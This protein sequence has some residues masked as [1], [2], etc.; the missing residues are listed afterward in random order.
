MK[1]LLTFFLTA[2]LAFGVGWAT[3]VTM[4]MSDYYSTT[5][6]T[7]A[8]TISE[9]DVSITFAKGQGS[10]EPQYY[11]SGR[12]IRFYASNTMSISVSSGTISSV[13]VTFNTTNYAG[14]ASTWS[15]T[16]GSWS[17]SNSNLVGTWSGSASSITFTNGA[18]QVRFNKITITYTSGSTPPVADNWYR[19]VTSASDLF[20]GNKYIIVNEDSGVGMGELN[21]NRYGTVVSGLTFDNGR[22][23]IGGTDVMELILGGSSGAWTFRMGE[24]GNYLSNS[25]SSNNTFFSS[26]SVNNSATDITKWTITPGDNARIQSNYATSQYIR[27][28]SSSSVFGTYGINSQ[29]AVALYVQDDGYTGV[30]TISEAENL[31]ANTNFRF[32]GNAVVTYQNGNYLWIRDTSGSGLINGNVGTFANGAILDAGW[33]ATNSTSSYGVPQFT[34]PS[35]VSSSSSTT[36]DPEALTTITTGDVNKYV[37]LSNLKITGATTSS[38]ITNYTVDGVS[39][40]LRNQ[41]SLVTLTTGKTYNVVGV[42]SI[43]NNQP[44][45]Y[46]ISAEEVAVPTLLAEPTTLTI[47]DSGTGNT[48]TVEGSALGT[49]N[50]GVTL[51]NSY[52]TPTV[53][54]TVGTTYDG[55]TYRGF[56]PANG[57][58]VG[59]VAINYAGRELSAS[60]VV[61]LGTYVNGTQ[62]SATVNVNYRSDVYILGNYGSGWDY[63]DGILMTYDA[64]N[65]TYT[66]S[67]TADAD[68]LIVFARKLGESNPW[69]TRYL[70]GPNSDP[71][72]E[73]PNGDWFVPLNGNGSGNLDLNNSRCIKFQTAGTYIIEINANA[74][75]F[76]I[77]KE[78]VNTGDFVL[79]TNVNDLNAG[80][81]IIFV[82]TGTAGSAY[83]MSTTQAT[84]NRPGTAVTVSNSLKVTATDE[85]QIFTLEGSSSGWYFH[86]VNGDNQGYIYAS[87]SSSNQLK[88]EATANDNAKAIISLAGN[89]AATI[90]FQGSNSRNHMRYN[91]NNG[92][93]IFACYSSSS[94]TGNL[95]Y[96]YKREASIEPTITVN[97][98]SMELVIPAGGSSQSGTATVTE[99]NTT[100]TTSVGSIT[101][102][103]ASNFSAS[104]NNGTLTV[105]YTGTATQANPDQAVITL[106]NGS[107]MATV[108]VTGYKLPLTV[109][110]TPADGHTFQGSTVTGIIESNVAGATIEYSFDGTTWQTYDPNEGFTATVNHVGGTVTVYARATYN[111]ETANAQATYTRIAPSTSCTADIVF[112]P[113]SDNG[114]MSQWSTFVNH[115]GEGADY[116]SSGTVYKLWTEQDYGNGA[117]R[118]GSGS[119]TG[120]LAMT[121]DLAKFTTG[122]CK[123][124]KVTINAARYGTDGENCALNVST[125]VNTDG[126]TLPITNSQT[127]FTDYVFNFNGSEITSLT[128][129]NTSTSNG[130][131]YVHSIS[132]EYICGSSVPAPVIT[133]ATGTYYENQSVNITADDG[134]TIYYTTNGSDPT[135]SSPV[136]T[137]PFN[138]ACTPGSTT[139]I[140]AIA[141]DGDGVISDVATEVYTW[142]APTVHIHP[143][144]RNT[145]ASSMSVTLTPDPA[146][147]QV[148]YTTDGSTPSPANGTLY[149]GP[150]TVSIPNVGDAVTVKAIA[151]MGNTSAV[152]TATYTHVESVLDVNVPFFS[153]LKD[154]TYYGD[155]TLQIGCTTP[156]ADIYYEI[157]EVSGATAPDASAVEDPTHVSTHYDGSTINMTVGNSYYVKAIAY[158][159]NNA[160]TISEG[161]YTILEAPTTQYYYT[162][163][164]DFNDNCPT[165]V[166]AH[167]VNPVQVVYHST[168][169][170]NGQ[171]AEF[172]YLRDNT[173]YACVYFGKRD[174]NGYHIFK[175]GDWIDGSQIAGVTNIWERNFHI[176]LG[177]GNHEV[178]SWPSQAIGWSEILPE[179][180]TCDVIVAGT[181]EGDNVWGHYVHLRNTRLSNVDDYSASD[182]KHTGLINDGTANAYYY[183][184][185]YRWSAGTCEYGDYSDPIQCLGDYDQAFFTAKQNAGATFDVYGVIDYYSLY[186]PPFEMCPIDFLW[187]YKPQMTPATTTS[188]EPVTVN[189]T[190]TQPEWAAEGVVI[191]YK[192]EDMEEWAV[193]TGPITVN[194][195]TTIQA[196]AEVPAEK[197]DGTNYNDYVRSEIVTETYTIEGIVDP[198]ISP[199]SQ[200]IEVTT[201]QESLTVTVTDH[202]EAGS[203]AVTTYTVN[204]VEYTLEAGQSVEIVVT[205]TT[206]VTAVS[207]IVSGENTLYSNE[208]SETYDFIT[209]NGKTYNLLTTNPVV[210][211]IYVIVN[212]ADKVGLSTTQ[213]ANNRAGIGVTFTNNNKTV[214]NGNASLAEFILES[215]NAGRYYFR[216]VGTQNYL[217]VTTNEYANLMSGS[218]DVNA[219]AAAT[220]NSSVTSGVDQSYPATITFYYDG[221]PRYLRYYSNNRTFTTYGDAT[222]NQD[223]FLYGIEAPELLPPT[224]DPM[225]HTVPDG[226]IL[227]GTVTP[228]E[229]NPEGAL[230]WYTTD[231]SDPRTSSTRILWTEDNNG[232]FTVTETTTVK[233]VTGYEFGDGYIYSDVVSETYTFVFATT[234][235]WI[236]REG[237]V[238]TEYIVANELVGA[239]AVNNPQDGSKLLWAKDQGNV[240]IDKRPAKTDDQMDYVKD[241]LQYEWQETWDESNWVILNFANIDAD[242]E[243]YVGHRI[244]AGTVDGV[245]TNDGNYEIRLNEAPGLVNDNPQVKDMPLYTGWVEPFPES[246]LGKNYDLAYNSFV[247]ANFM[248]EN[249]NHE[250]NG[251]VVG[252]IAGEGALGNLQGDELYFVN[253][254][255]QEVAHIWAVWN[256]NNIFTVYQ[257]EHQENQNINAWNLN[258]TFRVNWDYNCKSKDSGI[259]GYGEP[260]ALVQGV[261]YEFHAAIMHPT[262]NGMRGEVAPQGTP[263]PGTPS[264]AYMLYPLDVKDSGTPTAIVEISANRVAVGVMYYNLIGQQSSKPFEG[265]NIVVTR[266]SDGSTSAVKVL[267]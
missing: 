103:G 10:N 94:T 12:A 137:D 105:T 190:A 57:S 97:P 45:L 102:D 91:P 126:V 37:S 75:T 264:N 23:N 88:T 199:A 205:E 142:A 215:A 131:V 166:T 66:A 84:N 127:N 60:D 93:P 167:F 30:G 244:T 147:A 19:K 4:T 216:E 128:I 40:V 143:D 211:N 132:L 260:T 226:T 152:A 55:G 148:Y 86:T 184:K 228:D 209:P 243:D 187:A 239:W 99:E 201:G 258:G 261:A 183:D 124:T 120:E 28:N 170:N 259:N 129:K 96:I 217:C 172:C 95:A 192:T 119:Y 61:S 249:H 198:T 1:K 11:Y 254:K 82:N 179:E 104:L 73:N 212:K 52:F 48:F 16:E 193:Y 197:T 24:N 36:A 68:N 178:S 235:A 85:T 144:S 251:E 161:W 141:V 219:E 238:E 220:V 173:D 134:C 118:F 222:A 122:A 43:Y 98:T 33:T 111:G 185:F 44:Q 194:S 174:T 257:A 81:E 240:S 214:V 223:I 155:Q 181:S 195:T 157:V 8:G 265:I 241:I 177:T 188:F 38:G 145:T 229:E 203:G 72:P 255:I 175:M 225:S 156:N 77:T 87:S 70:F 25:N 266:Y 54:A 78:T 160:S 5:S 206:T 208:V 140:K 245:Y 113:T 29:S 92:S 224:I 171:F 15:V 106:T 101:G 14:Q 79:V 196:Y 138:V 51:T 200:V 17:S 26:Q 21:D 32:A 67:V 74:G 13:E 231:G 227:N 218:A 100:G 115:I 71:S 210:G 133:P 49:D 189:I 202:N 20:A 158:I 56:T 35:G 116:L 114:E 135:T 64:T 236:E 250:V 31:A 47:N 149:T 256:G 63:S 168:Y 163:L 263:N 153:P 62:V 180:M 130:R 186:T 2:L 176:Q 151:V 262:T 237:V 27:F 233:A 234:L 242:P 112:A 80:D 50:V 107:A 58:V 159:G 253:P 108:N 191:Y 53:T 59:E 3:E 169:T 125:N 9:G 69:N 139:T 41:F 154:H 230:T 182:P 267:Y 42:V 18:N 247:P 221:T 89:G 121:L 252:F 6:N 65:N 246:K 22:V 39:Y 90:V 7:D 46:L 150:F 136:Y 109:T 164:K 146:G 165:G 213:N 162:N 123:L 232:A 76:T 117:M 34:S 248:T 204:G 83:A 207:S 110:I